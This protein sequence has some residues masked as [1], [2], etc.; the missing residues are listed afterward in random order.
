MGPLLEYPGQKKGQ[1]GRKRNWK[2]LKILGETQRLELLSN[3]QEDRKW[4]QQERRGKPV[5]VP[6]NFVVVT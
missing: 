1:A 4:G 5:F 2:L 3:D 6:T